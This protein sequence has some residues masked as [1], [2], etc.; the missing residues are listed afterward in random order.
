MGNATE[1]QLTAF[2]KQEKLDLPDDMLETV[3]GGY[4]DYWRGCPNVY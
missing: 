3:A 1:E 2:C 4:V